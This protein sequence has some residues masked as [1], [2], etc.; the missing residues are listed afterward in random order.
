MFTVR[1]LM[2]AVRELMFIAHER[3]F[4]VREHKFKLSI[5]LSLTLATKNI[6]GIEGHPL[7]GSNRHD[8]RNQSDD[9]ID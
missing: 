2:F 5:N 1:E 9:A 6:K 4:T 7:L 3:M 8:L